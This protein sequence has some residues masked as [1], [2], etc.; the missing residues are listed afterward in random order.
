MF[1]QT[2][3]EELACPREELSYSRRTELRRLLSQQV[4]TM[5]SLLSSKNSIWCILLLKSLLHSGLCGHVFSFMMV[6]VHLYILGYISVHVC[7]YIL[8]LTLHSH[9]W[10]VFSINP[11]DRFIRRCGRQTQ[12]CSDSNPSS[13]PN[14]LPQ[15]FPKPLWPLLL[16][17]SNRWVAFRYFYVSVVAICK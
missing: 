6:C 13:L 9:L 17:H 15:P 12:K 16:S 11:V 4:P 3:S 14:T 8:L 10:Y 7:T 1:L 5:L 2:I